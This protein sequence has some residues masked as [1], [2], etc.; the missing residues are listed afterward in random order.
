MTRDTLR[1]IALCLTLALGWLA[2]CQFVSDN[3]DDQ[4]ATRAELNRCTARS[5][6]NLSICDLKATDAL[7]RC[8]Y[9]NCYEALTL[10]IDGNAP[11]FCSVFEK[12][13]QW[14]K[15]ETSA[16]CVGPDVTIIPIDIEKAQ[17]DKPKPAPPP[18]SKVPPPDTPDQPPPAD[19]A[20]KPNTSDDDDKNDDDSSEDDSDKDTNDDDNVEF[21]TPLD[22]LLEKIFGGRI[23]RG[24]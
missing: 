17:K 7:P 13:L 8:N 5:K 20:D 16:T 1:S 3:G 11:Y 19:D 23:P 15:V 4:I 6:E 21:K 10:V 18:A 24:L 2:S 12:K 22:K 14:I 9:D